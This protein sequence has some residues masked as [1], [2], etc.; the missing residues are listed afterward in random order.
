V[1]IDRENVSLS[2]F[3][4]SEDDPSGYII[5]IFESQGLGTRFTLKIPCLGLNLEDTLKAFEV[6][7][8]R[9]GK[10]GI[11]PTDMLEDK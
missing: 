9:A 10:D 2:C 3:K 5:R 11:R 1:E 8:Y 4:R 6:K 7:T